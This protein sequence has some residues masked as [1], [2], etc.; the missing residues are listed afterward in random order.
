ME[1]KIL[2]LKGEKLTSSAMEYFLKNRGMK[3]KGIKYERLMVEVKPFQEMMDGRIDAKA[4]VGFTD[5]CSLEGRELK[6]EEYT[7]CCNAFERISSSTVKGVFVYLLTLGPLVL[8]KLNML[9][10]LYVD[11]WALS[12]LDGG[13]RLLENSLFEDMETMEQYN[14]RNFQISY[15]YG[16]GF[17]G[18]DLE[19]MKDLFAILD[20]SKIGLKV[21]REGM[22]HPLK[23]C[24]GIY[25]VVDSSYEAP[26]DACLK[27]IGNPLG[28][29]V[30]KLRKEQ[31]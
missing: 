19:Q 4:M 29:C 18:M 12:Y 16:P 3:P 28:C 8:P 30:C 26:E 21:N 27:C 10:E 6:V 31:E 17:Y 13:R 23:S 24:G 22:I 5:V 9:Q 7:F 25:L 20:G 15:S 11:Y 14:G 2:N 1:S